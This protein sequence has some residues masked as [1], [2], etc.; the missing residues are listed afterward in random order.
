MGFRYLSI[1][2]KMRYTFDCRRL[3]KDHSLESPEICKAAWLSIYVNY[4]ICLK[5]NVKCYKNLTLNKMKQSR[6]KI[7]RYRFNTINICINETFINNNHSK[8]YCPLP[9]NDQEISF[10]VD[11]LFTKI[12]TVFA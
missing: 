1:P 4:H 11:K 3:Y 6:I 2:L 10:R 12:Y 7:Y 8:N 5:I 9:V